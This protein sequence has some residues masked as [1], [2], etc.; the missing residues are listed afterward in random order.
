M[1]SLQAK[2]GEMVALPGDF[3]LRTHAVVKV[4][5]SDASDFLGGPMRISRLIYAVIALLFVARLSTANG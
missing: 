2:Q 5:S 3:D 4:I 1:K